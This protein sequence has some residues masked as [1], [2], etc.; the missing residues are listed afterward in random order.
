[1]AFQIWQPEDPRNREVRGESWRGLEEVYASGRARAV[2][3]S[4]YTVSHLKDLLSF[5]AI[6][7]HVNQ[8]LE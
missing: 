6:T 8:V 1:M 3:V 5:A 2:G 7:P 4:N